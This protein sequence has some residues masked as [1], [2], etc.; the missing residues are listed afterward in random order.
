MKTTGPGRNEP[1]LPVIEL[2]CEALH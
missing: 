2:A 1:E